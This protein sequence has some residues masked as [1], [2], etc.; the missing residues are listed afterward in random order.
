MTV[1]SR[2]VP[3]LSFPQARKTAEG[4]IRSAPIIVIAISFASSGVDKRM[5]RHLR[6]PVRLF[7][8]DQ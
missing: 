8:R 3:N 5:G 7:G 6:R 1:T 2:R 4:A